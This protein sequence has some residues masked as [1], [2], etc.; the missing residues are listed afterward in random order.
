MQDFQSFYERATGRPPHGYQ[1]RIAR[2]GLPDVVRA[3]AGAG[4]SGVILAWLWRRLH[5]QDPAG[6]ARRLVYALPQRAALDQVAGS[7]RTWLA[8]LGLTERVALHVVL[9]DRGASAG[10]WRE[11]MHRPAIV[12]GTVDTL[13]SK[14]LN[15]GFGI[16]P[17]MYPIDF[18]LVTNGAQWVVVEPALCQATTATLRQ[19]AGWAARWGTAEPFGLTFLSSV[20]AA[21]VPAALSVPAAAGASA[22]RAAGDYAALA[23]A[24]R[25]RHQAGTMTLAV[26]NTVPGAQE[27]YRR[28]RCDDHVSV[29]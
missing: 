29:T 13:V 22:T 26:L 1:A 7:V 9:G 16:A 17:A 21:S 8:N 12:V 2:D 25:E 28:L 24:V 6:T 18:A 10:D 20:P 11:N 15:R 27:V 4:K 5:G 19:V 14:A 3:P 23:Q